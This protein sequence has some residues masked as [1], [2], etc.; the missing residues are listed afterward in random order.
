[1]SAGC[2]P[3]EPNVAIGG[4]EFSGPAWS[5]ESN[6]FAAP[7]GRVILTWLE[8]SGEGSHSLK[9]AV[10]SGGGWSQPST[11]HE[12][13]RFFVNWADF[14][15]L[16]ELSGGEWIVH[17]LEKTEG[18]SYAYHVKLAISTDGGTTW[19]EPIVP[20]RDHSATEHGFVSMIP[21]ADGSAALIW[22]D[23]RQMAS[24]ESGGEHEGLD[25]GE[26]SLRATM[27]TASGELARDVLLDSRTCECCQT[28]LVNANSGL[29]AAYR[30]RGETELRDIGVLRFQ[31]DAWSEPEL[32][33]DDNFYYP[34]CPVNGPQL[35]ASGDDVAIAWYTAP[36]QQARVYV[37][38]SDDGGASFDVPV[39]VDD[40]DPLGRVDVEWMADD[41]AVVS[42]LERSEQAADVKVR[43]L[44]RDGWVGDSHVVSATSESRGSGFPRLALSG[45]DVVIAWTL[46]GD[47]GGVRVATIRQQ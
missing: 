29:V 36:E 19:G 2:A 33:A 3:S 20:H 32:V 37:A 44:R 38:F 11:I 35:S 47:D 4:V 41:L 22:L 16:V 17:W 10:R 25:L 7:D 8:P 46:I 28:A 31:D 6:L 13:D 12:S 24:D 1:M 26:M 9:F 23:G 14:P 34:G 43:L 45:H 30:D 40:G 15:S 21:L 5:G 27:V 42:W 39:R 18:G